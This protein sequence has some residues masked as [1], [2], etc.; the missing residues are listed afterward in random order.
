MQETQ[1]TLEIG[2]QA[3]A[4]FSVTAHC[5]ATHWG[6]G[7]VPVLATPQMI[8]WM[9]QVAS[10]AVA[11]SLPEGQTTVGVHLDVRHLAATLPGHTV[12]VRATLIAIDGRQLGF[13]VAAED[14]AGLIGEGTHRRVIVNTERFVAR[15]ATRDSAASGT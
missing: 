9:E 3:E 1:E 4:R 13:A 14:A 6:S 15:A 11:A 7:A 10:R 12:T 5:L 8:A 2:L